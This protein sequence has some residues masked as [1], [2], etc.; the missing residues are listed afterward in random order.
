MAFNPKLIHR[1]ERKPKSLDLT[2][3]LNRD[4]RFSKNIS[5]KDL[6]YLYEQL[7]ILLESGLDLHSS[8]ELIIE[9]AAKRK[10]LIQ[11]LIQIKN[12]MLDGKSLSESLEL[13]EAFTPFDFFAIK[14]GENS[15]NLIQVFKDL[16]DHYSKR[17]ATKRL[18]ISSL[19]YPIIVITFTIGVIF[20]LMTFLVPMFKDMFKQIGGELPGI[21]TFVIESSE[22]I[23]RNIWGLLLGILCLV[24]SIIYVKKLPKVKRVVDYSL[25]KIPFIKRFVLK[26]N[27]LRFLQLL[28]LLNRSFVPIIEAL[29]LIQK[30]TG[31]FPLNDVINQIKTDLLAGESFSQSIQKHPIFEPKLTAL[32]R[33]GEEGNKLP[34][35][36]ERLIDQYQKDINHLNK[37]LTT[38]IEP[39]IVLFLGVIVAIVLISMYM[40][41]F[42]INSGASFN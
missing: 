22:F 32:I 16:K 38:F 9:T 41:L 30:S 36:Y 21:T 3:M 2:E 26:T 28:L 33:V 7:Y 24:V 15:G 13:S 11:I 14:I 29:N 5:N 40:P 20:F 35:I 8:I 25:I 23:E 42:N 4:I 34:D 19:T 18:I 1:V 27:V 12:I 37:V 39:F 31:F 6:E 10:Y 17:I